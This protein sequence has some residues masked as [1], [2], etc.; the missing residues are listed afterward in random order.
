MSHIKPPRSTAR[1]VA[2]LDGVE[3]RGVWRAGARRRRSRDA[4]PEPFRF[5]PYQWPQFTRHGNRPGRPA[6]PSW[7]VGTAPAACGRERRPADFHR[8][9]RP[10]VTDGT[11]AVPTRRGRRGL[12]TVADRGNQIG[13]WQ[14]QQAACPIGRFPIAALPAGESTRRGDKADAA[15]ELLSGECRKQLPGGLEDREVAMSGVE[16]EPCARYRLGE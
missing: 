13:R 14:R 11:C 7:L 2:G 5:R 4:G 9:P 8:P 12:G 3:H 1:R 10:Q 6:P 16:L 15:G